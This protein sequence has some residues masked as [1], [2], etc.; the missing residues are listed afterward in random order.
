MESPTKQSLPR[1]K[2]FTRMLDNP[3]ILKELKGRMRGRQ[4][5][6][7]MTIY[8]MLISFFIT[9]IYLIFYMEN[10]DT[11]PG[12]M[13]T[14]GK[15][16]FG[17]IVLLELLM[18]G[19]IGPALT[20]GAISSERERQTFDLLK[21]S[22]LSAPELVFGKLSSAV[23]YLLLLIFTAIPIQSFAFFLGGIGAA[24]MIISTLMLVI[25]AVFFCSLGLFFSS[26]AKRTL[27]STVITYGSH[28]FSFVFFIA[29]LFMLAL[30]SPYPS[31][32]TSQLT[33]ELYAVLIWFLFSTNAFF[34]AIMSEVILMDD[35]SLFFTTNS[36]LGSS[37]SIV[38]SPWIIYVLFYS[39]L[40][41]LLILIS[42]YFVRRT[43]K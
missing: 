22:L 18:I 8:L 15:A 9:S 17:T 13:Q 41:V 30:L 20:S 36:L 42:I 11:S 19:F 14:L 24:E 21:I 31:S 34:A 43:E 6:V 12:A 33:R 27:T 38:P 7:T 32:T 25:T 5:F 28:A 23:F 35:Q 16:L 4:G 37:S 39:F 2:F 3:V 40:T 1:L 26:F 29:M 10:S